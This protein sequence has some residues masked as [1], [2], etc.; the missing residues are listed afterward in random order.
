MKTEL[1]ALL[2][3]HKVE[4]LLERYRIP[5]D[6]I[7]SEGIWASDSMLKLLGVNTISNCIQVQNDEELA[8]LEQQLQVAADNHPHLMSRRVA[9][10]VNVPNNVTLPRSE[11]YLNR[12]YKDNLVPKEKKTPVIDL[13]ASHGP[14]LASVDDNPLVI[15]D[16]ASQIAS[17][18]DGYQTAHFLKALDEGLLTKNLSANAEIEPETTKEFKQFVLGKVSPKLKHVSFTR[19]GAEAL[20]KAFDLCRLMGPGGKRVVAFEG[21]F[22]GRTTIAMHST[23]NPAKRKGFELSGFETRFAPFPEWKTPGIEPEIPKSWVEIWQRGD[24]PEKIKNDTLLNNEIDS[25]LD[26]KKQIE[27]G[28]TCCVVVEPMQC[29][30][31]DR[32]ATARFFHGLRAL[33][34]GLS[35]PLVF[36]EVQTGFGLGGPFFWHEHFKL[37]DPPDCV[38]FGKRA[39]VGG[40]ISCEQDPRPS[41]PH[42]IHVQ[43]GLIQAYAIENFDSSALTAFAQKELSNLQKNYPKTISYPRVQGYAF[44]FDMPSTELANALLAKRFELGF[45]AYIAGEKTLRFRLN[46]TSTK[47]EI[48]KLFKSLAQGIRLINSPKLQLQPEEAIELEPSS[49][50]KNYD[51][52]SIS[53]QPLTNESWKELKERIM[54]IETAA[55]EPGRREKSSDMEMWFNQ[56]FGLGLVAVDAISGKVLGFTFGGPLETAHANGCKQDAMQGRNNTFYSADLTLAEEAQGKGLG[57]RLKEAQMRAVSKMKHEDGTPRYSFISGRNKIDSADKMIH[58]NASLGA[59][60]VET[61]QEDYDDGKAALYYRIPLHRP[62]ID[63]T[64]KGG[65]V[66]GIQKSI[67][68][69][70]GQEPEAVLKHIAHGEFTTAIGTKLTL[71]NWATPNY[72]RYLELLKH[73]M[74]SPMKH[75]YNTS[76]QDELVDKGLRSLKVNRPKAEI[77]LGLTDQFFGNITAAARSLSNPDGQEKPFEWFNWPRLPHPGKLGTDKSL[78]AIEAEL[79]KHDAETIFGFVVELIGEK[80][81]LLLDDEFL[82]PLQE[83]LS[84]RSIPLIYCETASAL[85]RNGKTL[86]MTDSLKTKPNM[87]WWYTGGQLGH[88]FVDDNY[89]VEQPLTLI[90]TWDGDEISARRN[91][92]H[93]EESLKFLEN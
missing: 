8:Q 45:M 59:Y 30:G 77:A 83:M 4:S 33:T 2:R 85:G 53:I 35:V 67:Q 61:Y 27:K 14:Y 57:R 52:P 22:H 5:V 18:S 32:Y 16:S 62:T 42:N 23:Y 78:K 38:T 74:P 72:I 47:V 82:S 7:D 21:S 93:I 20:E 1:K 51:D 65:K 58:L 31:G 6:R 29:E 86:F 76:G 49:S 70:L 63:V 87:I 28:D 71:S 15:F 80:S 88:I 55:Y 11:F 64:Q 24:T 46:M 37:K 89:F 92:I 12:I 3:Q 43:R 10:Q 25:L 84:E 17:L 66:S 41:V 75:L 9:K 48:E 69:P 73:I 91:Y 60:V 26:V 79:R 40:V 34:K 56:P 19:G 39:Q 81:G 13:L 44:A 90:S 68:A 50:D 36:D 54:Q